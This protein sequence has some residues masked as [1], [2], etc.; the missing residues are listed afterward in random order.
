MPYPY[1]MSYFSQGCTWY[2]GV[3]VAERVAGPSTSLPMTSSDGFATMLAQ[4]EL[5]DEW[6]ALGCRSAA[7]RAPIASS[8]EAECRIAVFGAHNACHVRALAERLGAAL[9]SCAMS[10]IQQSMCRTGDSS[11]RHERPTSGA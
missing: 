3:R 1:G 2:G 11:S 7:A 4:R 10:R 6:N 9:V 5:L 8:V